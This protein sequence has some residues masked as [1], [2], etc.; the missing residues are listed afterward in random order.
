MRFA[1]RA[2]SVGVAGVVLVSGAP[3]AQATTNSDT[4]VLFMH[5]AERQ[6][7][8][9][10]ETGPSIGDIAFAW[11]SVS[12]APTSKSVGTYTFRGLTVR[13]DIPGGVED[14]DVLLQYTLSGGTLLIQQVIHLSLGVTPV[15]TD[16]YAI[17]GGTGDFSGAR[18]SAKVKAVTPSEYKVTFTFE[19]NR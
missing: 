11:G 8:D 2:L 7:V 15:R 4:I 13:T 19:S 9:L 3:I 1:V 6:V 17:I 5:R 16:A 14:R 18:G 10:G 12:K